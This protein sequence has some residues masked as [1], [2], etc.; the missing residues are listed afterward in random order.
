MV[1]TLQ[2]LLET[3]TIVTG[4][5]AYVTQL[6]SYHLYTASI[7]VEQQYVEPKAEFIA[8]IINTVGTLTVGVCSNLAKLLMAQVAL[9]NAVVIWR[10]WV[11]YSSNQTVQC[12]LVGVW[13]CYA[14]LFYC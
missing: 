12:C 4:V 11:L 6:K 2:W 1:V 14:G 10:A 3:I 7:P 8:F 5:V 13:L 9:T